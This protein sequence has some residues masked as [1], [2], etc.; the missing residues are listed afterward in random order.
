MN[1]TVVEQFQVN[2]N[3]QPKDCPIL[4]TNTFLNRCRQIDYDIVAMSYSLVMNIFQEQLLDIIRQSQTIRSTS[5]PYMT[6]MTAILSSITSLALFVRDNITLSFNALKFILFLSN[7]TSSIST[8][9]RYTETTL[10]FPNS[11]ETILEKNIATILENL[12]FF[13]SKKLK[14]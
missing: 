8:G 7:H 11:E 2:L 12:I 4:L 6:G 13:H 10:E 5:L 1:G 3:K 9:S 14:R